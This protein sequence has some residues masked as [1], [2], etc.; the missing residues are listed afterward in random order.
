L[1]RECFSE[2][3]PERIRQQIDEIRLTEKGSF[4]IIYDMQ[5]VLA[6]EHL[7]SGFQEVTDLLFWVAQPGTTNLLRFNLPDS[8]AFGAD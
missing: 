1:P 8:L 7:C 2:P 3:C 4:Y 5:E 6:K